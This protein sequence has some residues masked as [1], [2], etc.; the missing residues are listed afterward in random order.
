MQ[1]VRRVICVS[2]FLF[3]GFAFP[4]A[5]SAQEPADDLPVAAKEAVEKGLGAAGQKEWK[6]AIRY[7]SPA[8]TA[9][10]PIPGGA[11]A[12]NTIPKKY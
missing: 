5:L 9:A 7:A 3:I 2:F 1:P 11:A 8:G 10:F 4:I 12:Q 6:L